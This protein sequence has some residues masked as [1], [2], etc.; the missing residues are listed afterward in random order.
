M[1][2]NTEVEMYDPSTDEV[3][4]EADYDGWNIAILKGGTKGTDSSG[5]PV[6]CVILRATNNTGGVASFSYVGSS[7]VYLSNNGS[8]SSQLS[9]EA[10]QNGL[11][12]SFSVADCSTSDSTLY[13]RYL[14]YEKY[15]DVDVQDGVTVYIPLFIS[16]DDKDSE[17]SL[18]ISASRF[19]SFSSGSSTI[20]NATYN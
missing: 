19:G 16:L 3:L 13:D 10:F 1:L 18:T 15:N 2:I 20:L 12:L 4:T 5:N 17:I 9:F 11:S 7:S 6:L 8:L 14:L